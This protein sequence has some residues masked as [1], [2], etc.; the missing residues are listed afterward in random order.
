VLEGGL[1]GVAGPEEIVVVDQQAPGALKVLSAACAP[2]I[3][4]CSTLGFL[5]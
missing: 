3:R 2:L 1:D 4:S 5:T